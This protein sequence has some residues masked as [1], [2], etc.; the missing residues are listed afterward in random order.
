MIDGILLRLLLMH[1]AKYDMGNIFGKH[2]ADFESDLDEM[3]TGEKVELIESF[4][5]LVDEE[6]EDGG[7]WSNYR[8]RVFNF[9]HD[10]PVYVSVSEEVPATEMQEGSDFEEPE[11]EQ[12]YPHKVETIVYKTTKPEAI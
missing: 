7:R 3:S 8:T 1:Y 5:K 12:V 6:F 4:G 11:I 10:G 9:W 2:K